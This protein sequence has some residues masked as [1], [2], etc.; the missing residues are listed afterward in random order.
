[1][2]KIIRNTST[3]ELK[4]FW[5][6]SI[7]NAKK[8][9]SWPDWKRAGI[10]EAH[11]RIMIEPGTVLKCIRKN[12][13][14]MLYLAAPIDKTSFKSIPIIGEIMTDDIMIVLDLNSPSSEMKVL[15]Y[16][17]IVYCRYDESRFEEL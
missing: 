14:S 7:E 5:S 10:N 13:T 16:Y 11:T 6:N 15:S 2:K 1:M 17:G 3:P 8:V 9:Q 4:K 12:P